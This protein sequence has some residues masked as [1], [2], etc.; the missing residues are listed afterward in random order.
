MAQLVQS[1]SPQCRYTE[2]ELM[3][4]FSNALK[5]DDDGVRC[6]EQNAAGHENTRSH[7]HERHAYL[8]SVQEESL[9]GS[10]Q[11]PFPRR[12]GGVQGYPVRRQAVDLNSGTESELDTYFPALKGFV[13]VCPHQ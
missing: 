3:S 12:L 2:D 4:A 8:Q 9:Q 1:L 11:S 13:A 7:A 6:E 5:L 10:G